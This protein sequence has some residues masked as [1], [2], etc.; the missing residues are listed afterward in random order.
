MVGNGDD[1][2]SM[3]Q[4]LKFS[5]AHQGP[6]C[7]LSKCHFQKALKSAAAQADKYKKGRWYQQFYSSEPN[8]AGAA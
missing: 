6:Q 3:R 5:Q 2:M 7:P 8:I 1:F 4:L